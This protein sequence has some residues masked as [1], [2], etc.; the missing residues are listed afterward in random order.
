[1][2]NFAL[3]PIH[4][5]I[6]PRGLSIVEFIVGIA[7][8]LFIV[9]GTAKLFVDYLGSNRN[10]LLETRV[11]QDLRA[12]ADYVVRDLRRAGYWRNA[13]SGVWNST[14][15][16]V[17]TN[18]YSSVLPASAASASLV[19]YYDKDGTDTVVDA[20]TFGVQFDSAAG[21]LRTKLGTGGYQDITDASVVKVTGFTVDP[22]PAPAPVELYQ[23]CPCLTKGSCTLANFQVGGSRYA[24]RPL[25]YIQR[26]TVRLSG[27]SRTDSRIKREIVET[28]RV[29]NDRFVGDA[30]VN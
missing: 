9:G 23:T 21:T 10:M 4:R 28:V 15:T 7:V 2:S 29:R 25:L 18:P 26:L 17:S 8:G 19:Y 27:E 16:S 14:T 5:P 6:G 3:R 1:M 30:C 12:A 20:E 22:T 24:N 11:N 13:S